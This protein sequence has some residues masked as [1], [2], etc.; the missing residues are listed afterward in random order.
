MTH[1]FH[2][3][4]YGARAITEAFDRAGLVYDR[5]SEVDLVARVAQDLASD[6]IVGWFQGRFEIGPRALG[7]R[8]ILASPLNKDVKEMMNAR[9]KFREPFRPFAPAVLAEH[10]AEY[11][12]IREGDPYMTVAVRVRPEKAVM[13][14]AAV[15]VDGTARVQT[16]DRIVNP[17][18]YAVIEAFMKLTGV[19]VIL[20]TSFN[21]QE[22][23][24]ARPEEAISCFL[25]TE[26]DVVVV[27]DFYCMDRNP[28]A[29][30]RAA[31]AF[32]VLEANRWGGE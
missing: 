29:V 25:R 11:F 30:R 10:A 18:Y 24:V 22:P 5:L 17:R 6:K 23:I 28:Q 26:M 1:A 31:D 14:P 4:E 21:K 2:G 20:N 12:E 9:I 32:Q 7:N 27:G 15:H 13:I 8:S 19:P 3:T 16:V